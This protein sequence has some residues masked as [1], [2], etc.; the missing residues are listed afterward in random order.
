MRTA[1]SKMVFYLL[2]PAITFVKVTP[3]VSADLL[4]QWWPIAA[5]IVI[6]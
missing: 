4:R 5:N 1:L 2:L 6:T 3:A